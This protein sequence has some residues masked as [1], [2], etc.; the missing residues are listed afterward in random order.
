[1]NQELIEKVKN[2]VLSLLKSK[3]PSNNV[4]H[5]VEHTINVAEAAELIGKESRLKD[6]ELEIVVIA[7]WFHDIG[8]ID[9]VD[10]HEE[11]SA[12]YAE[13]FLLKEGYPI[14]KI[15]QVKNCI[16]ATKVP[17][18]PNNLLEEVICDADLSHLGKITFKDRN[19]LFREEFESYFG[20]QLTEA[21]WLKKSIDFLNA[22]KF[23]TE[24]ARKEFNEQKKKN[25]ELLQKELSKIIS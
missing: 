6:D 2:Y 15:E 21:E 24:Y 11:L 19:D 13:E 17:Q 20:R 10:G 23:F 18:K 9:K 5:D 14:E 16:K 4:Y 1:M 12:K 7:S 25:I 8:Y 22:H 3:I